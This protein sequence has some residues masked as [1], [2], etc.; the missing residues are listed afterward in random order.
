MITRLLIY[1]RWR[2]TFTMY[3]NKKKTPFIILLVYQ[4]FLVSIENKQYFSVCKTIDVEL[5]FPVFHKFV[6]HVAVFLLLCLSNILLFFSRYWAQFIYGLWY[7]FIFSYCII[8]T[9]NLYEQ[10][11]NVDDSNDVRSH[12]IIPIELLMIILNYL[13][14]SFNLTIFFVTSPYEYTV[15]EY[16]F[17][18][19]SP[20]ALVFLLFCFG[21]L[22]MSIGNKL[23]AIAERVW[24]QTTKMLHTAATRYSA[25]IKRTLCNKR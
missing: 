11:L 23:E 14:F 1:V 21:V 4:F 20:L 25:V 22:S 12:L 6:A 18:M 2:K 3:I 10:Y 13:E 15:R 16:L 5:R 17:F 24:L 8:F 9:I 19:C 7:F